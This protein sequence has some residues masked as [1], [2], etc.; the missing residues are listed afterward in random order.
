MEDRRAMIV[1]AALPLLVE[2]GPSVTTLQ[3][4]RAAGISEPTVFRAFADKDEV[5]QAC[6][7]EAAKPEHVVI[8]L[9]AID[10]EA[11]LEE[12]LASVIDV[13]RAQGERTGAVMN[14]VRLAAPSKRKERGS[15]SDEEIRRLS[16]SRNASFQKIHSAICGVLEG[17]E[18]RLRHSA[19]E[20]A[21]LVIRMVMSLGRAGRMAGD[22]GITAK[23]LANLILYGILK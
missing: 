1:K 17:D 23:Q 4:A 22:P 14:A 12:R 3:I 7:E 5:L 19:A 21:A 6:L 20:I 16:E 8:E 11:G 15:L 13:I 10:K 2:I 9:E 18:S